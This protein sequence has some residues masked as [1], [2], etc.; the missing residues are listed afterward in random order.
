MDPVEIDSD[1]AAAIAAGILDP[2]AVAEHYTNGQMAA[3]RSTEASC[4]GGPSLT[5]TVLILREE[6]GDR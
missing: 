3:E 1:T 6:E 2:R 5:E 4:T